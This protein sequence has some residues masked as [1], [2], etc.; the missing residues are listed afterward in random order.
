MIRRPTYAGKISEK[1]ELDILFWATKKSPQ[2]RLVESWRLN[3][4][5]NNVPVDI[6]MDRSRVSA[7][8]RIDG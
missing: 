5:N 1:D 8:K 7:K 4:I 6:K 2:E 3:C